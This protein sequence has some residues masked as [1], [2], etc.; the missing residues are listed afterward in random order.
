MIWCH[1]KGKCIRLIDTERLAR[2][3]KYGSEDEYLRD[4][5]NKTGRI[6]AT[7]SGAYYLAKQR[8]AARNNLQVR[9]A[10]GSQGAFEKYIEGSEKY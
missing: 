9:Q 10:A 8:Q 2:A 7:D 3:R 4:A 6:T 1:L 5:K